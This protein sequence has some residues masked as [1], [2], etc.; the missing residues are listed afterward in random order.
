[1]A[2]AQGQAAPAQ[3]PAATSDPIVASI[4]AKLDAETAPPKEPAKAPT[5]TQETVP[6]GEAQPAEEAQ[7]E[8]NKQVEGQDAPADKQMAEIPL[9]QLEAIELEVTTKGEDGKDVVEKPTIKEL[10]EGYMRQKDYSRKTAEVARQRE[11]VGKSVRQAVEGERSQYMKN[12]QE[13]QTAFIETAAPELKNVD[14]NALATNDAFEYVRLQN[15]ANQIGQVLSKIQ[16]KQKEVSAKYAEEQKA[17]LAEVAKKSRATLEADIPNF[18]DSLYQTLMKAG[19]DV[20]YKPEEV[21]TWVDAR[22]I[23]L[24]HKAYLY[25]QLKA[26]KPSADKKVVTAP[27]VVK[28]GASQAVTAP[29]QRYG[30]AM[31][32]LGKSGRVEDAADA[33]RAKIFGS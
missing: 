23:K 33:I 16:E 27:K 19:E 24:L 3:A 32:R 2:E 7:P 5:E 31:K 21:A 12:L 28:P 9:D 20:G 30:D 1:M 14:W 22:A 13:L 17:A 6:D 10:R 18:N 26:G 4:Q 25:D 29:Q 11:E 15:R 8:E